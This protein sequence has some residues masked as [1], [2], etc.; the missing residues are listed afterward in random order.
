M[1]ICWYCTDILKAKVINQFILAEYITVDSPVFQEN[2]FEK[3]S[4]KLDSNLEK[5]TI[6]I[7]T[8]L[9]GLFLSEKAMTN[10]LNK[11]SCML[12]NIDSNC[13]GIG[14]NVSSQ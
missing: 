10:L 14:I 4:S 7:E 13:S 3:C 9:Q 6:S 1:H 2:K 12:E 8:Y 5:C 11:K